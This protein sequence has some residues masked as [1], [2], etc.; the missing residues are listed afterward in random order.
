MGVVFWVSPLQ[1]GPCS[2]LDIREIDA[3]MMSYG[4]YFLRAKP[5]S[6]EIIH[7]YYMSGVGE[8]LPS[9]ACVGYDC[10]TPQ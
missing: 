4:T 3:M 7:K 10:V 5:R 9:S 6:A 1:C 2:L 8:H